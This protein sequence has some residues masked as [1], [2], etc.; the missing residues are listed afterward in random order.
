MK[1][2]IILGQVLLVIT[3][4]NCNYSKK[5]KRVVD[6]HKNE[7]ANAGCFEV[8]KL[9]NL[10]VRD[11]FLSLQEVDLPLGTRKIVEPF[12]IKDSINYNDTTFVSYPHLRQDLS[13][14]FYAC[15]SF[16]IVDFKKGKSSKLGD[17]FKDTSLKLPLSYMVGNHSIIVLYL[18]VP[19]TCSG[20]ELMFKEYEVTAVFYNYNGELIHKEIP[21]TSI[22]CFSSTSIDGTWINSISTICSDS[23]IM[24]HKSTVSKDREFERIFGD[25]EISPDSI[26]E[27]SLEE[28]LIRITVSPSGVKRDTINEKT[29]NFH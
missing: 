24:L 6:L 17:V 8:N 2:K 20:T 23:K 10:T 14:Q 15:N 3:L 12:I 27:I 4:C 26:P 19:T 21:C 7:K 18:H 9:E 29:I 22:E 16:D 5:D 13:V 1:V 25:G 28:Q 11:F